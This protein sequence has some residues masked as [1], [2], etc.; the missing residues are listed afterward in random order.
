ME[1]INSEHYVYVYIDPRNFEEFYYGMGKGNRK[2]AHLT[3]KSD[4]EKTE[5]IN[6]IKNAG[7][8]PIIKVI[9]KYLTKREAFLIEKTLILKLGK[10]LT[11]SSS[12]HFTEKFRPHDTFH[13]DLPYFDFRNGLYYVNVGEGIHRCWEDCKKYG[14]L[15][16]GQDKKWSD[17]IR[18]LVKGDIVAAYAKGY[19]YVG[20]GRVKEKAVRVSDFKIEGMPLHQYDLLVQNIYENCENGKS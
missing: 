7:K 13:I 1:E 20:I 11:N 17:P 8:E 9:A 6:S 18:R 19:G 4:S 3:D 2:E 15:S 14:F 12:G 16:A 5:R 10:T